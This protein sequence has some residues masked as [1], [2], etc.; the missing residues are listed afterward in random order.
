MR[1]RAL[2]CEAVFSFHLMWT[3]LGSRRLRK[4]FRVLVG[5][6]ISTNHHQKAMK[7]R[8]MQSEAARDSAQV[9]AIQALGW[10]AADDEIFS[11]FLGATG[12][13]LGEVRAR[14]ADADFLA[15]VLDFL[16][17]DDRWVVAFCDAGG[18]PYTAVQAAR[19]ALPGGAELHWT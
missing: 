18:H 17:Q 7:A 15:A 14:A 11:L 4:S 12:V 9:L 3:S 5:E 6:H 10:I 1:I 8:T 13:G 2:I 16:M 19:A